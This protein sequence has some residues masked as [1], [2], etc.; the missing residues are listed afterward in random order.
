VRRLSTIVSGQAFL[1]VRAQACVEL[2]RMADALE[3]VDVIHTP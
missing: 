3:N 1:G 2:I